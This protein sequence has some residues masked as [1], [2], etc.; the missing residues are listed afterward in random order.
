MDV[1]GS[2]PPL[3]CDSHS[4]VA[5]FVVSFSRDDVRM[6]RTSCN[7]NCQVEVVRATP[8]FFLVGGV[9][10]LLVM[11]KAMS[12]YPPPPLNVASGGGK[13]SFSCSVSLVQRESLRSLL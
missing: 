11:R 13:D 2:P 7:L 1:D 10:S 12:M 9:F 3:F 6:V 8:F 4:R 5:E